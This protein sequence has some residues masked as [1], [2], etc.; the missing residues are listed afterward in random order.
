MCSDVSNNNL[1]NVLSV[2]SFVS[3]FRKFFQFIGMIC[4]K[5]IST[6]ESNRL[7]CLPFLHLR[8]VVDY[9][10][11]KYR[12]FTYVVAGYLIYAMRSLELLYGCYKTMSI[13]FTIGI[14]CILTKLFLS[15]FFSPSYAVIMYLSSEFPIYWSWD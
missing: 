13:L 2:L 10:S 4:S 6:A 8:W 12:L 11:F 14:S 15:L 3:I 7:F 1:S 5:G 9:R